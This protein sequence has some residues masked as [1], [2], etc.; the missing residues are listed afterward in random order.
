MPGLLLSLCFTAGQWQ[1]P[2][3]G[4]CGR[5]AGVSPGPRTGAGG[6]RWSR[7]LVGEAAP[8][9]RAVRVPAGTGKGR[10]GTAGAL[11]LVWGFCSSF[12]VVWFYLIFLL[13]SCFNSF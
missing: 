1:G 3:R 12:L 6:R 7:L 2:A 5:G 13:F 4:L 8:A 9:G 11:G 10:E